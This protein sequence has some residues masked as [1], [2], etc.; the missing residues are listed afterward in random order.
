MFLVQ[1]SC[2]QW[3]W[4]LLTQ[5]WRYHLPLN[6]EAT[7]HATSIHHHQSPAATELAGVAYT[8]ETGIITELT[9]EFDWQIALVILKTKILTCTNGNGEW[10]SCL[11]GWN[12]SCT[13]NT[14]LTLVM[15]NN[16]GTNISFPLGAKIKHIYM[17]KQQQTD[18]HQSNKVFKLTI[19]QAVITCSVV[20]A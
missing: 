14:M 16:L 20:R 18:I 4:L 5:C 12:N 3:I 17:I 7:S 19:Q 9:F 10:S 11:A 1:A 6:L 2:L 13:W 15:W 8:A